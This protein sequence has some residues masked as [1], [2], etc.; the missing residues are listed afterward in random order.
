[1]LNTV[2]SK[3]IAGTAAVVLFSGAGVAFGA[4]DAG[5]KLK[6][7]YNTQFGQASAK[8]ETDYQGYQTD[9]FKGFSEEVD[10]LKADSTK[11]ISEVSA[12]TTANTTQNINNQ[13]KEH[14]DA[15]NSQKTAILAGMDAQFKTLE[16]NGIKKIDDAANAALKNAEDALK[17]HTETA[18]S[19]A[20]TKM[21]TDLDKATEAAKNDLKKAID[22]AKKDLQKNLDNKSSITTA[23]LKKS[24]DYYVNK[25]IDSI[26]TKTADFIKVQNGIIAQLATDLE[27]IEKKK[28]Q[29]VVD[30]I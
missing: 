27:K 11:K 10:L 21:K 24:V 7:W 20:S 30:G 18:G 25:I 29:D 4:S 1:M 9:K 22:D 6:T 15:I 2:K 5:T 28:L 3:V 8:V 17:K 19:E 26:Q 23:A 14:I 12:S 13:N 16:N